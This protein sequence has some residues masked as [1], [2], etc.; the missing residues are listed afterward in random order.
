MGRRLPSRRGAHLGPENGVRLSF[1]PE[2]SA[3]NLT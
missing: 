2:R 1:A 3:R